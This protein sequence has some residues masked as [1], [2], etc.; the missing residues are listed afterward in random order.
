MENGTSGP[1]CEIRADHQVG[2]IFS[3]GFDLLQ[4][5]FWLL[6][7]TDTSALRAPPSEVPLWG[8]YLLLG[9]TASV[10]DARAAAAVDTSKSEKQTS[11]IAP[12]ESD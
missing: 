11:L 10:L 2:H 1:V 9:H 3:G 7:I 5:H 12:R 8:L 4:L 6:S